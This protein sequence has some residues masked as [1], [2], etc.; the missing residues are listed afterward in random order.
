[1]TMGLLALVTLP[2]L[3]TGCVAAQGGESAAGPAETAAA[4]TLAGANLDVGASGTH[5]M[6]TH[7]GVESIKINGGWWNAVTPLY[8]PSGE[9]AGPP[10]GWN[11]PWQEGTLTLEAED[12]AVFA[13]VGKRVVLQPSATDEPIRICR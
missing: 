1:M 13:A 2:V 6:L 12:R 7:C 9:G 10:V 8:G 3:L 4:G 5:Q 11:E